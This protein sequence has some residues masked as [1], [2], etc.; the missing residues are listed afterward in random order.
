[1]I[2]HSC[3]MLCMIQ[4]DGNPSDKQYNNMTKFSILLLLLFSKNNRYRCQLGKDFR[5]ERI[6][7]VLLP[8]M[9]QLLIILISISAELAGDLKLL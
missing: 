3:G 1:M 4:I 6:G 2:S 9:K 8:N 5:E 7:V